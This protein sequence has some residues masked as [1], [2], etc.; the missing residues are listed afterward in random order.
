MTQ[1]TEGGPTAEAVDQVPR[2]RT[3]PRRAETRRRLVDAAFD[4]LTEHGIRDARIELICERAGF[5]RGAFYSNF[6]SKEDLFLAMYE[7]QM[8]ERGE[9]LRVVIDDVLAGN[10]VAERQSLRETVR[11]IGTLFMEPLVPDQRWHLLVSEFRVHAL[12]QPRLREQ[13]ERAQR[14]FFDEIGDILADMLRRLD[15]TLRVTPHDAVSVLAAIYEKALE[16]ALFEG[17]DAT[18]DDRL[19]TEV[20]PEVLL[21]LI[22]RED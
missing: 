20:L 21:S 11:Q 10:V 14:R 8:H 1:A 6:T 2:P 3:T 9:R 13:A 16:R 19:L 22:V 18:T 7:E 15:I 12:R 17:V 4:V 5:S